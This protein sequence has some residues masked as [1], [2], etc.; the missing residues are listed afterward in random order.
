MLFVG[1]GIVILIILGALVVIGWIT[2]GA[3]AICHLFGFG[4]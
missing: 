2:G 3:D 1:I 4:C